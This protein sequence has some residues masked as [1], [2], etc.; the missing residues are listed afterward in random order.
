MHKDEYAMPKNGVYIT[1]CLIEGI[2][3]RSLTNIGFNPTVG[4]DGLSIETH[5]LDYN[6]DLYGSDILIEFVDRIRDEMHFSS[7][8]LLKEQI[9]KDIEY[10]KNYLLIQKYRYHERF[11]YNIELEEDAMDCIV[12]KLIIQPIIE[13]AIEYGF[14]NKL[15]LSVNIKAGFN[16]DKL[17]ILISDNGVGM[18][19]EQLIKM[20]KLLTQQG[21]D[22]THIGLFNVH[23]RIQLMYGNNYGLEIQ[24]PDSEGVIVKLILPINRSDNHAK[25]VNS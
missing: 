11:N 16:R 23:R 10:T 6:G 5:I 18:E 12:P 21:N 24:S 17:I 8:E 20:Q 9:T 14:G 1:Q 25:S 22:S 2:K 7:L 19:T 4:G 13:N 3:Y 15:Q